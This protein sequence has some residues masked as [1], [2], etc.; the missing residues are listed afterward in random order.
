MRPPASFAPP[1]DA[2]ALSAGDPRLEGLA[3][4]L[5]ERGAGSL[6]ALDLGVDVFG[7]AVPASPYEAERALGW[8]RDGRL[9]RAAIPNVLDLEV[10]I[11]EGRARARVSTE[12]LDA[13]PALVARLALEA[14]AAILLARRGHAVL[15]AG[16]VTRGSRAVVVR[17]GAGAGKSTLVAACHLAGL[18]VLGDE[19]LLASRRDPDALASSVRE[20]TLTPEGARLA[21]VVGEA[22]HSGGE[23]KRRVDLFAGSSPSDRSARRAAL[24]LLGDRDAPRARLVRLAPEDALDEFRSAAID[25]EVRAGGAEAVGAVWCRSGAYRLDGTRDLPAAVGLVSRL[26]G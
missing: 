10:A 6:G 16:A 5:W 20:L 17:G 11:D 26:L 4:R 12:A 23:A 13:C 2:I 7:G 1:G 9:Y 24:V 18:G 22:A 15:H 21:G 14:P 19:S 3:E 25:E 8:R